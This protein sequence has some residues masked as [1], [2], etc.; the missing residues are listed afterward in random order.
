MLDDHRMCRVAFLER[1]LRLETIASP[2]QER[3]GDSEVHLVRFSIRFQTACHP[4]YEEAEQDGVVL[5]NQHLPLNSSL[6]LVLVLLH[7]GI[8]CG[9]SHHLLA[10]A[11]RLIYDLGP[12]VVVDPLL[13]VVLVLPEHGLLLVEISDLLPVSLLLREDLLLVLD[14]ALQFLHVLVDEQL[15]LLVHLPLKRLLLVFA[16]QLFRLFRL[17]AIDGMGVCRACE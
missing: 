6:H 5:V 14:V 13:H 16:T 4:V 10:V 11:S 17:A 2:C 7:D 15:L 8:I 12:L 1:I 3:P 9:K